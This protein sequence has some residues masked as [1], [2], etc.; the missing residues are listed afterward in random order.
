MTSWCHLWMK[1]VFFFIFLM[2]L[3][4]DIKANFAFTY[5]EVFDV[6]FMYPI[7]KCMAV[8]WL[9]TRAP[10]S[11]ANNGHQN[12]M[13][14]L[15]SYLILEIG[16][17]DSSPWNGHQ[18]DIPYLK[19]HVFLESCWVRSL[20]SMPLAYLQC[21]SCAI[22]GPYTGRMATDARGFH[23]I[24]LPQMQYADYSAALLLDQPLALDIK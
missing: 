8:T 19:L 2:P 14:Y 1:R 4:S 7:F 20:F 21:F 17:R 13:P 6:I 10:D 22:S 3:P 12:N 9:N 15:K 5:T 24:G 16:P 11:C 23:I 18:G